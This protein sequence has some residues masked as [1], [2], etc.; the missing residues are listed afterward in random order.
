M[1]AAIATVVLCTAPEAGQHFAWELPRELVSDVDVPGRL[2]A[3]G[4][5]VRL[6][7]LT[8]RLTAGEVGEHFLSSFKRQGLWVPPGMPYDRVLTGVRPHDLRTF[9]VLIQPIDSRHCGVIL[10]EA[11]PA[12]ARVEGVVDPL[13]PGATGPTV[14]RFESGRTLSFRA[15]ATEA[16]LTSFYSRVLAPAGFSR[17][18]AGVW[19]SAG[20]EVAVY[21][22]PEPNQSGVLRV[23]L[24][25][26]AIDPSGGA[27]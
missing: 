5:P 8:V 25:R 23:V 4:I 19:Q 2:E 11:A 1:I 18:E 24:V 9:T 12:S 17:T 22:M 27:P 13:F 26:R 14:T 20:E 16:E 6:R 3:G 15:R 21:A 10:G 7:K